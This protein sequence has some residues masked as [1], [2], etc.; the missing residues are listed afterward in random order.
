MRA[1]LDSGEIDDAGP[2]R[3]SLDE[4]A[5]L[6]RNLALPQYRTLA[7]DDALSDTSSAMKTPIITS[8]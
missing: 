2:F 1:G 7:G 4:S 8:W 3:Q 6:A 5:G